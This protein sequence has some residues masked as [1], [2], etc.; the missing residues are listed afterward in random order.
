MEADK[1]N[2]VLF[3]NVQAELQEEAFS[4]LQDKNF[5]EA[6]D[7]L[8]ELLRCG[9]SSYDVHIGKLISLI[10]L[11]EFN[12]AFECCE[13]LLD[14]EDEHYIDYFDYFLIILYEMEQ[15]KE[16]MYEIDSYKERQEVPI[17]FTEKF[18]ML[19]EL[20][21]QMNEEAFQLLY[22]KLNRAILN[23]DYQ[24]Q[25]HYLQQLKD[26]SL[27]PPQSLTGLLKNK[28]IHPVIKTFIID[29]FQKCGEQGTVEIEKF[30]QTMQ[31]DLDIYPHWNEYPYYQEIHL[32]I[33]DIEQSNPTL[34]EI[35]DSLLES[36]IYVNYP[37]IDTSS[38]ENIAEALVFLAKSHL[39]IDVATS[40]EEILHKNVELISFSHELYSSII[41]E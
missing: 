10:N 38:V 21:K 8:N 1:N 20:S 41:P 25:W 29:W 30:S 3:P 4:A 17:E 2:V 22:K 35:I 27:E 12:E 18:A 37:M 33:S 34:Y 11:R 40:E 15:Y 31:V 7:N 5:A 16:V 9:V 13:S 26:L 19:Y 39:A 14:K 28:S 32:A 23:D 24:L 36:Y 6:L